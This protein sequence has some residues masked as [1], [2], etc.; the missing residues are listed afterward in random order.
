MIRVNRRN[1]EFTITMLPV[2]KTLDLKNEP[3]PYMNCEP[4]QI[5]I[6]GNKEVQRLAH[7]RQMIW[8]KG[9][10]K[11]TCGRSVAN[12]D[13]RDNR[14]LEALRQCVAAL[15]KKFNLDELEKKLNLQDKED[16]TL[17]FTPPAAILKPQLKDVPEDASVMEETQYN[18][19]DTVEDK[20]PE[21][22]KKEKSE[23]KEKPDKKDK[24]KDKAKDKEPKGG[25]KEKAKGTQ[26]C[27]KRTNENNNLMFSLLFFRSQRK[28]VSEVITFNIVYIVPVI[29]Q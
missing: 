14:E 29:C 21:K 24:G 15:E 5:R 2:K 18:L 4:V 6:S 17:D 7:V 22:E 28:E 23:K 19:E 3:D 13:C 20:E 10:P 8:E 9:F 1:D 11:C 26:L 12:C 27:T 16:L 25:S